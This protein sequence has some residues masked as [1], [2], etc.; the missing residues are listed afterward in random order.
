MKDF[1]DAIFFK[2]HPVFRSNPLAL[3]VVLYYDD[4]EVVNPLR[5]KAGNYTLG[6][7]IKFLT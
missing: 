4:I 7:A 2:D 6:I 3:Q 5:S 1:C